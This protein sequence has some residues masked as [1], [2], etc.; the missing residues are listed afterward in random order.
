MQVLPLGQVPELQIRPLVA[1][2]TVCSLK[3]EGGLGLL[4]LTEWNLALL[5]SAIW[6]IQSKKDSLW[7][8][9]V[10]KFYLR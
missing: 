4:S 9:W 8:K 1:W 3:K 6:E 5:T 10:K 7:I 2:R